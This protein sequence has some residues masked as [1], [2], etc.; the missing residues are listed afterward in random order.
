MQCEWSWGTFESTAGPPGLWLGKAAVIVNCMLKKCTNLGTYVTLGTKYKVPGSVPS[1]PLHPRN[2]HMCANL[3]PIPLIH[4]IR[5]HF[6]I[7]ILLLHYCI[8]WTAFMQISAPIFHLCL[9]GWSHIM[10]YLTV[11]LSWSVSMVWAHVC[12]VT[13]PTGDRVSPGVFFILYVW[14]VGGWLV[15]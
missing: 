8:S 7:E 15:L 2:S 12:K 14:R 5:Q 3:I 9:H 4:C 6:H 1:I 13:G 10:L 11:A